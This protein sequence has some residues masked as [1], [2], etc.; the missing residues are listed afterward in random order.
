MRRLAFLSMA[1]LALLNVASAFAAPVDFRLVAHTVEVDQLS[2]TASFSL[3]FNQPPDFTAP[4][5]QPQTNAF[6]YEIDAH[7]TELSPPGSGVDFNSITSVIRGSE[8]SGNTFPIRDRDGDGGPAAGGWGPVRALVNFNTSA[9]NLTF[10][11]KFDALGDT[12]GVFRYRLFTTDR[13]LV[14]SEASGV[15][16]PLP[17]ALAAGLITMG[18]L[19]LLR[20]LRLRRAA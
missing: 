2:Q 17:P 14:T 13:G 10:S 1:V 20:R 7:W 19:G 9:Q 16:V 12:D 3:T 11:T 15:A 5:G 4:P 8:I 18:G 6:Q